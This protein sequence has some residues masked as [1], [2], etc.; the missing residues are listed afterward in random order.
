MAAVPRPPQVERAPK[1]LRQPFALVDPIASRQHRI[2]HVTTNAVTRCVAHDQH[3]ASTWCVPSPTRMCMPLPHTITHRAHHH[4]TIT[5]SSRPALLL[6]LVLERCMLVVWSLLV[7]V[8][9]MPSTWW[10][11]GI[12]N[13]ARCVV[14]A[15]VVNSQV[16]GGL[17]LRMGMRRMDTMGIGGHVASTTY[18]VSPCCDGSWPGSVGGEGGS[19]RGIES[20]W[21]LARVAPRA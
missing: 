19:L 1:N 12:A 2:V 9:C 8:L 14:G 16:F 7:L 17:G 3:Q 18:R 4:R 10:R 6:V 5:L 15:D 21:G 13:H 20:S 11:S